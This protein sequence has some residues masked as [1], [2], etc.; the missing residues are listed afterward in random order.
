MN[1]KEKAAIA[2]SR[3]GDEN[4]AGVVNDYTH[5]GTVVFTSCYT[6]CGLKRS[7]ML[8]CP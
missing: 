8:I 5:R 4:Q 2:S 6:H 7:I 3:P 1:Q